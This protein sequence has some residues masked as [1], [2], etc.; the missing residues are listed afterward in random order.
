MDTKQFEYILAIAA[1][2]N[3]SKA[4]E[5]LFV[6]QPALSQFLSKLE[7]ELGVR[8][9]HHARNGFIPTPEGEI[10]IEGARRIVKIKTEMKERLAE[11]A[12]RKKNRLVIGLTPGRSAQLLSEA[13]PAFSRESPE[14]EIQIVEAPIQ[15][16]DELSRKGYLDVAL[17]SANYEDDQLEFEAFV[18]EEIFFAIHRS[19]RLAASAEESRR[20]GGAVDLRLF[21]DD[22][23]VMSKKG[24]RL[25]TVVDAYLNRID[26]RPKVLM[27]TTESPLTVN[28]IRNNLAVGFV[29]EFFARQAPDLVVF[30]VTPRLTWDFGAAYRKGS[31]DT[32]ARRRF[33]TLMREH[34]AG[35]S[36]KT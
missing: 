29:P 35:S 17:M 1:E 24:Y 6:S 3:I 25:R 21:K 14:I 28:M 20:G 32:P 18:T 26:L 22:A 13:L 11:V 10:Y 19:H 30:P 34:H 36:P 8:L 23:F 2:K 27:E 31:Q 33:I 5:A 16:I 4:A 9:F 15:N 7:S 12:D